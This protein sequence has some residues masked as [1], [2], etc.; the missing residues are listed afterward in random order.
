MIYKKDINSKDK[1]M[2]LKKLTALEIYPVKDPG[3]PN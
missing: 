2:P 1:K 3:I